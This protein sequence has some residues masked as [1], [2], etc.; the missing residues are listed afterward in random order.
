M[1]VYGLVAMGI[2]AS[3]AGA[4]STL[5]VS[6]SGIQRAEGARGHPRLFF[7]YPGRPTFVR[8]SRQARCHHGTTM[9]MHQ[10]RHK[11]KEQLIAACD[12]FRKAQLR[13]WVAEAEAEQSR[14]DAGETGPEKDRLGGLFG[15]ESLGTV[16]M[17]IGDLGNKTLELAEKLAAFNPTPRPVLGWRGHGDVKASD[18]ALDGHWRKLFTTAAD[19][20][21]KPSSR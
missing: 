5:S 9:D 10:E 21:F 3:G 11:A 12:E 2:F 17:E 13:L 16:R 20:T 8:P 4:F 14:Q 18:C 6:L 7:S 19:A 15:A 1:Q